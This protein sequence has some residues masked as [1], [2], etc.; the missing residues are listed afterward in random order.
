M[1]PSRLPTRDLE[2]LSAY[3]DGQLTGAAR[4]RVEAH[5]QAE[6]EWQQ[7][8]RQLRLTAE[9]LRGLP[10]VRPQRHFTLTPEMVGRRTAARGYPFLQLAT[11]VAAAAFAVTVGVEALSV[12]ATAGVSRLVSPPAPAAESLPAGASTLQAK[13]GVPLGPT[14]TAGAL[15]ALEAGAATPT[16]EPAVGLA[17]LALPPSMTADELTRQAATLPGGGGGLP[18]PAPTTCPICGGLATEAPLGST[19]APA[20]TGEA[21]ALAATPPPLRPLP[22]SPRFPFRAV[23]LGMAIATLVLAGL[24]LWL[25]RKV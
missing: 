23:E 9:L 13:V 16:P 7:A 20:S 24:T 5:L 15:L 8:A 14:A 25:R 6:P 4:A 17:P 3:L 2:N 11:V 19:A 22:P 1:T 10:E 21:F 18:S 12:R